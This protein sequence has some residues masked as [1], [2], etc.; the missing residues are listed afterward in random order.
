ME[1]YL[2]TTLLS[3]FFLT[4]SVLAQKIT[5]NERWS[6]TIEHAENYEMYKVIKKTE[7]NELWKAVQDSLSVYKVEIK[8]ET[9]QLTVQKDTISHLYTTITDL[10]TQVSESKSGTESI[11]F[12]GKPINKY[13]YSTI[14]WVF[15]I[16]TLVACGALF[17]MFKNSNKIT[18]QAITEYKT[19]NASFDEYK[20]GKIEMERKLRREIQTQ[21]NKLEELKKK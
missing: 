15:L 7:L 12:M 11:L 18:Q 8:N 21:A 17:F 6:R 13:T 9:T 16:I 20:V 14:L 2:L 5:L 4:Q 3:L 10:R 19:L 1:K